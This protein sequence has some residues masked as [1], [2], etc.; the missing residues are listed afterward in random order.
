MSRYRRSHTPGA[1]YFFTVTLEVRNESTRV[2]H[3]DRQREVYRSVAARFPFRTDALGV[4]P[5]HLHAIWT[6]PDGNADFSGR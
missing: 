1:T 4:L 6:L 5:D 2:E 3:I